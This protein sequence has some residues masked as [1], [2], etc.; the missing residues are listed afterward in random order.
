MLNLW[1]RYYPIIRFLKGKGLVLEVGSGGLGMG[2][3]VDRPFI[4]CNP[5]LN[6]DSFSTGLIPVIASGGSLPFRDDMFETVL[7]LDTV[8]HVNGPLRTRIVRELLR[9]AKTTLVYS[10]CAYGRT[11]VESRCEAP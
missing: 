8:G 3:F 2:E 4:G 6:G 11:G 5:V 10:W 9:V 7:C 1:I